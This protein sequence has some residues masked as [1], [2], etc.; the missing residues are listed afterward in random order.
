MVEKRWLF[1]HGNRKSKE[2]G[3]FD[4]VENNHRFVINLFWEVVIVVCLFVI[5]ND[6]EWPSL[7]SM[8]KP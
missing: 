1:Y 5:V 2:L 7:L 6:K 8:L 4:D 3:M